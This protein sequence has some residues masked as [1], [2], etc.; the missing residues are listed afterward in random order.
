MVY[1]HVY[2]VYVVF[3]SAFVR[4]LQNLIY[5]CR[6]NGNK[7]VCVSKLVFVVHRLVHLK[8]LRNSRMYSFGQRHF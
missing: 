2:H 7:Y 1:K 3:I 8:S 6:S 5:I 4:V